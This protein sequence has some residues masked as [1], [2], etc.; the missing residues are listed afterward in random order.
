MSAP[1]T[2]A[3]SPVLDPAERQLRDRVLKA[4]LWISIADLVMFAL[5]IYGLIT[6]NESIKPIFGPLHGV[7]VIAE[8]GLVA[9]GSINGWWGWWYSIVTFFTTGPP[10]AILGHNKAKREALGA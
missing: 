4:I 10:G 3:Q 1:T 6:N 5:L 9:W 7:G 8:I 2:S